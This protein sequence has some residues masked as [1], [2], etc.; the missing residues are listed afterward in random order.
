M[1]FVRYSRWDGT[2]QLFGLDADELMEAL[3]DDLIDDGDLW[4]ALQRMLRRGAENQQGDRMKG[5]QDL[6]N[7]LRDRRRE[8]LDRYNMSSVLDDLRQKLDEVLKTE[9]DAI[10]RR[11]QEGREKIESGEAPEQAAF[12]KALERMADQ[13]RQQLDGMPKDMAGQIQELQDYRSEER[14]VGKE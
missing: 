1:T 2:Q 6:I 5:L 8:Q 10:D 9:R 13:K 7:Q 4:S 12:Q 11:V 14:R 3:S